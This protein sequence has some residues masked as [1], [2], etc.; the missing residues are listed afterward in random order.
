MRYCG[1]AR[2]SRKPNNMRDLLGVK[3][4][5]LLVLCRS[6]LVRIGGVMWDCECEC[7]NRSTVRAQH[8][9]CG[10][11]KS[12]GCLNSEMISKR[13]RTH[14]MSRTTEYK[15]W[16]SM[17][18]RCYNPK[19]IEYSRYGAR[20]IR[21]CDEW[22]DSFACFIE[23]M[24]LKPT[25]YHSIDRIDVNGDYAPGNCR[26]ADRITQANNK[27]SN[28]ILIHSGVSRTISEWERASGLPKGVIG[29]RL[30]RGMS[31]AQAITKPLRVTIKTRL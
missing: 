11:V 10:R 27:R 18:E 31:P 25:P 30:A 14:G 5:R 16:T 26:W 4:G 3:F 6:S 12:C 7:G 28:R 13:N 22:A 19:H 15:S 29:L 21:V 2:T 20:G 8:L 17:K 23:D 24:G 1:S 9:T